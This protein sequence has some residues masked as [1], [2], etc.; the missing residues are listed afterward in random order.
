MTTVQQRWEF[1]TLT[2]WGALEVDSADAAREVLDHTVVSSTAHFSRLFQE[3]PGSLAVA[4]FRVHG[5]LV[6]PA[7]MNQDEPLR[8]MDHVD[9]LLRAEGVESRWHGWATFMWT[10]NA[11][12]VE[13]AAAAAMPVAAAESLREM[14]LLCGVAHAMEVGDPGD[15]LRLASYRADSAGPGECISDIQPEMVRTQ[16]SLSAGEQSRL[17]LIGRNRGREIEPLIREALELLLVR[18]R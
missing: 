1:S 2:I 11:R 16:F 18:H 7:G 12:N 13:A 15:A 8:W 6:P 4:C 14:P 10:I 9:K 3:S 5:P 17:S